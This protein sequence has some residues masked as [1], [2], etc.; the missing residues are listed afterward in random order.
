MKRAKLLGLDIDVYS[1]DEAVEYAK[2]HKGQ[3]VT[4]NPEMFEYVNKNPEFADI[5]ENAEMVIPDGIGVQLGLRV[6]GYNVKRIP[7]IEFAKR[8][9]SEFQSRPIALIGAKPEILSK[10]VKNLKS[11]FKGINI[12]YA[13]DGYFDDPNLV[14]KEVSEQNPELVLVA[15]GS[16][17]QEEFIY[18]LKS[19]LPNALMVG[20]G[21][22]F[23]VWSGVVERAPEIYQRLWLEWLYRAIKEPKRLKRIFPSLPLFII[24]VLKEKWS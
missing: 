7:G 15:L 16:P 20:V 3:V 14:F 8:L 5:I 12:V 1:F 18:K 9:I 21:G 17:K 4:I 23:D 19:I 13:R 22:S 2:K 24:Q 6:M 11:E 10:T